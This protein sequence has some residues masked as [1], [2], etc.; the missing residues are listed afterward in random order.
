MKNAAAFN[1][2]LSFGYF[3]AMHL[4]SKLYLLVFCKRYYMRMRKYVIASSLFSRPGRLLDLWH[5]WTQ[6]ARLL[7]PVFLRDFSPNSEA[8]CSRQAI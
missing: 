1:E 7:Q 6:Q 3:F 8:R 5:Q 2:S 4:I